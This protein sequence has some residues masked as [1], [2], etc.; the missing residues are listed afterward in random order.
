LNTRFDSGLFVLTVT[1]TIGGRMT[2]NDRLHPEMPKVDIIWNMTLV[3]PW[4][5]KEC[6]VDAVHVMRKHGRILVKTAGLSNVEVM[7]DLQGTGTIFDQVLKARQQRGLELNLSDKRKVLEHLEGF[8]AKV[9]FSGGDVLVVAENYLVLQEAA[10]RLGRDQITLTATGAGLAR[11]N[12]SDIAPFIGELNFTYD[13]ISPQGNETRPAGYAVGNLKKATLFAKAG[14]RTRAECPLSRQNIDEKILRQIYLD[15]H[16]A[17][18]QKLLLMR[19]FPVGRGM[20]RASDIPTAREY[21]NTI[22]ILREMEAK[23]GFPVLKL[24]CA[25]KFFD[26]QSTTANPCDLVSESFGLMAD[27]TLLS[28][29]WAV[30]SIGQPLDDAWILGNLAESSLRD[31]LDSQKA[32]EYRHR[33]NENF[34]HCKIHAFINSKQIRPLDRIFDKTDPLY[35]PE[36]VVTADLSTGQLL[37]SNN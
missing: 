33:L 36:K 29:P 23:Y 8:K 12:V 20:L 27:G 11:Y 22:L 10:E 16:H 5:C 31:I 30:N 26:D 7:S 18:V 2:Y 13:N 37:S 28:S 21:K 24:Q 9:D 4:D 6:C 3:C 32:K 17:G 25:L 34:G 1:L 15:V 14:V 19:L 35:V